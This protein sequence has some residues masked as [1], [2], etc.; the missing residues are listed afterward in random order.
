MDARVIPDQ[1]SDRRLRM[2]CA[3]TAP[4]KADIPRARGESSTPRPFGFI[5]G[6]C[7]YWITRLRW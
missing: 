5:T 1:A 4:Q 2:N 6:A 3:V 7:D